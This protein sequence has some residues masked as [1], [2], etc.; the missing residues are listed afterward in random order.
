MSVC[1]RGVCPQVKSECQSVPACRP[2][3][4]YVISAGHTDVRV[5]LGCRS[6]QDAWGGDLPLSLLWTPRRHG[7]FSLFHLASLDLV[8]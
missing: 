6:A 7:D 3:S 8:R 2:M 1:T 5:S 4:G